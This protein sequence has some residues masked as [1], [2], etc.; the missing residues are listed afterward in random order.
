MGEPLMA[1]T[2]LGGRTPYALAAR[3]LLRDSLL[4]AVAELLHE[5]PWDQITMGMVAARAGVS[6]QTLY[7]SFGSRADFAQAYVLREVDRFLAAVKETVEEHLEDPPG[8]LSAAFDLFL[9]TAA[10]D[11]FVRS[12]LADDGSEGLL[13]LVTTHGRP[14]IERAVHGLAEIILAGWPIVDAGDANLLAEM[15][16]R[17]AISHAGLPTS[18]TGMTAAS[19]ARLLGP[20]IDQILAGAAERAGAEP[21]LAEVAER[22]GA[23]PGLAEVAK[24]SGDRGPRAGRALKALSP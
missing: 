21:G 18:P 2:R 16:V 24:G 12:I 7:K 4:D 17:Q 1:R 19:L 13:P 22:A 11:P 23:E 20:F 5:R 3:E 10:D 14:M 6:R 15:L 8:A 9:K